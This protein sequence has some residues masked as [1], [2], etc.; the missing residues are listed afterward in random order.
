MPK[1]AD[2]EALI[3]FFREEKVFKGARP[4][5]P[6]DFLRAVCYHAW[7]QCYLLLPRIESLAHPNF[8][9]AGRTREGCL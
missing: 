3:E 4:T 9:E 1:W 5:K 8:L 7:F 6:K 2:V